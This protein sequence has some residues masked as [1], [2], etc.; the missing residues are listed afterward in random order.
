VGLAMADHMRKELVIDTMKQV[1]RHHG[2]PEVNHSD[3]GSQVRQ[4]VA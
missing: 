2:A 4:E 3:R 1:I